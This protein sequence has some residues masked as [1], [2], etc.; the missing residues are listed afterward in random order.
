MNKKNNK[1]YLKDT[2][3]FVRYIHNDPRM[4]LERKYSAIVSTLGH[5]LNGLINEDTFFSP[6]VTGYSRMEVAE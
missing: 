1:Q 2:L 4:S 6:R 3:A 5:D